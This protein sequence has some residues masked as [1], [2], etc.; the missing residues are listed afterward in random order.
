MFSTSPSQS[1]KGNNNESNG[2]SKNTKSTQTVNNDTATTSNK[3]PR[4][5]HEVSTEVETK[6]DISYRSNITTQNEIKPKS[7][8]SGAKRFRHDQSLAIA[9]NLMEHY[10]YK[11]VD[12]LSIDA[13]SMKSFYPVHMN[14][15]LEHSLVLSLSINHKVSRRN[16]TRPLMRNSQQ[17]T[18]LS[19]IQ[20]LRV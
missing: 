13:S 3:R 15:N 4:D 5:S 16:T 18:R 14:A 19:L 12:M 7:T 8:I 2:S 1:N 10:L 6:M 9:D 17:R 20:H 11:S